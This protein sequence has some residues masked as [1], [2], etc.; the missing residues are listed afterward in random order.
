MKFQQA[1]LSLILGAL[2][3]LNILISVAEAAEVSSGVTKISLES[4]PTLLTQRNENL[5]ASKLHLNAQQKREGYLFRSF[6]PQIKA[7]AGSEKFKAGLTEFP[8]QEYWKVEASLNIFNGGVDKYESNLRKNAAELALYNYNIEYQNELKEATLAF[9][10]ALAIKQQI[11]DTNEAIEKNEI[12]IKSARRRIGAGI[13]TASDATQFELHKIYLERSLKKLELEQDA[14]LNKL[15]VALGLEDHENV[16]LVGSFPNLKEANLPIES[17]N[18]NNLITKAH[19]SLS[20]SESTKASQLSSSWW[21]KVDLYSSYGLPSLSDE[22]TRAVAKDHEWATGIR[23]SIDLGKSLNDGYDA[24]SKRFEANAT[25]LRL[26]HKQR[27]I[28]AQ[29]HELVH[30]MKLLR[31]LILFADA[32][33]D[34]AEKFLKITENEYS[35]GVK[36][37]PDLLQA[38]QNYYD[39]RK[40]KFEYYTE[41]LESELEL[42]SLNADIVLK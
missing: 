31:E 35:R 3:I 17:K 26:A 12:N 29:S 14:H 41:Y 24:S 2:I 22:T 38:F 42:N 6:L 23:V 36:N 30:H 25:K 11:A 8:Q 27:E 5:S 28:K 21:P 7:Q 40:K 18:A 37:G 39:F 4:I 9:W 13:V 34:K 1:Q 32:D 16:E 10:N 20:E 33:T 15:G 19:E